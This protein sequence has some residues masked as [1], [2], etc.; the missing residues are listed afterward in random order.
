MLQSSLAL[1]ALS[2]SLTSHLASTYLLPLPHLR[3][4]TALNGDLFSRRAKKASSPQPA[5]PAPPQPV[6]NEVFTVSLGAGI[7]SPGLGYSTSLSFRNVY[8]SSIEESSPF[9]NQVQV[10]DL[11]LKVND[12]AVVDM[13]FDGVMNVLNS[14]LIG[15]T[16]EEDGDD[17][18]GVLL[19]F[20]RGDDESVIGEKTPDTATVTVTE[21]GKTR[22]IVVKTGRSL[23]DV[24]IENG[25][26]PYQS[27]ARYTNCKGKQLCG[28]CIVDVKEG[29]DNCN[30]KSLDETS[31][32]RE[33]QESYRL[34]CVTFIYG[35]VDV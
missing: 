3:R 11:M 32:L 31:T 9:L 12:V 28:T 26:N 21:G 22:E 33:N 7:Q 6:E 5:Q 18:G 10:G 30:R 34:S 20:F 2:L 4:S 14:A 25:I 16:D 8:V 27:V 24:L 17:R 23:R 35:D 13:S 1:F 19:T 29:A 15:N